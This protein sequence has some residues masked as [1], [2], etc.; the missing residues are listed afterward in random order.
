M[1]F[2]RKKREMEPYVIK[3]IAESEA[4]VDLYGEVV[5]D[6]PTDWWTGE[7]MDGLYIVEKEFLDDIERLENY[8]KVNFRINSVGGDADAGIAIYNRIK[9]MKA[10]TT[11][12]VD[13]LAA[14]AASII[15]MAGD[16]RKAG[17]GSQI[18]IHGASTGLMGYYNAEDLKKVQ[19]MLDGYD[20]S[21]ASI[22]A[23]ETGL[24]K[25]SVLRMLK[26]TEWMSAEKAVEKGFADE[27]VGDS[28]P[29]IE[30][31]D[32][33]GELVVVNGVRH[34]VAAS[35][36][37]GAGGQNDLVSR[38]SAVMREQIS[39]GNP[40]EINKNTTS[41]GENEM[42]LEQLKEQHPELVSEILREAQ[43]TQDDREKETAAKVEAERKRL[44]EIEEI[45]DKIEDKE[46]V[47]NAK[48]GENPMNAGELALAAMKEAAKKEKA[49]K[50]DFLAGMREDAEASGTKDVVVVPNA[51]YAEYPQGEQKAE[52]DMLANAFEGR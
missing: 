40:Q 14:S 15:F 4:E 8:D 31:I 39:G 5:K 46:L 35:L 3:N 50:D 7:K 24:S 43:V 48:Y 47:Q 9:S 12:T 21:L 52:A 44:R 36:N 27:I 20:G 30:E 13:G 26:A 32:D 29:T 6:R 41:K 38:I 23:E 10:K 17:R 2:F 1:S 16:S 22:Y 42:T 18:M 37:V 28:E 49:A 45:E 25:D 19:K 34:R 51:G 11:T 33:R